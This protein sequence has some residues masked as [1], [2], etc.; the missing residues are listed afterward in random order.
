MFYKY[1][2]VIQIIFVHYFLLP[3]KKLSWQLIILFAIVCFLIFKKLDL[4]KYLPNGNSSM[5]IA[6]LFHLGE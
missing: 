4:F 6:L 5:F 2:S 1:F 3:F